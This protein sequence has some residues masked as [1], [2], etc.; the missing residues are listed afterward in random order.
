MKELGKQK[1]LIFL[2]LPHLPI[3]IFPV[4]QLFSGQSWTS[5]CGNMVQVLFQP[6]LWNDKAH[7]SFLDAV[8][9][10]VLTVVSL[11]HL[12]CSTCPDWLLPCNRESAPTHSLL[13]STFN[14]L[15]YAQQPYLQTPLL[16][17]L[18]LCFRE[19]QCRSFMNSFALQITGPTCMAWDGEFSMSPTSFDTTV[20]PMCSRKVHPVQPP[21][22]WN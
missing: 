3:P 22:S 21:H 14:C 18:L 8:F 13:S 17:G 16:W 2:T 20:N 11:S 1:R 5:D 9:N 6:G 10:E 7:W 12:A 15:D 4:P 19:S